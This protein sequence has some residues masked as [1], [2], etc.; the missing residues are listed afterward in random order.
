M[1][2]IYTLV[3]STQAWLSEQYGHEDAVEEK[4]E[5]DTAKEDV[6]PFIV[7]MTVFTL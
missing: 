3:T 1:A 4:E 2:M 7:P 5:N 6:W